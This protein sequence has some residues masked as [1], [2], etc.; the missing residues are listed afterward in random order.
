MADTQ[1]KALNDAT[2]T[3][4]LTKIK[5]WIASSIPQEV[6]ARM[7]I[8]APNPNAITFTGGATGT[9]DGS[10]AATINIPNVTVEGNTISFGDVKIGVD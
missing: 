9:Y 10:K 5:S 7:P 6:A 8:Q 3:T 4:I 1:K 2:L